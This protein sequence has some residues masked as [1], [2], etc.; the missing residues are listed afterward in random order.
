MKVSSHIHSRSP[1]PVVI[2]VLFIHCTLGF[3]ECKTGLIAY[4]K[5]PIAHAEN[6]TTYPWSSITLSSPNAKYATQYSL[7]SNRYQNT[8]FLLPPLFMTFGIKWSLGKPDPLVVW[9]IFGQIQPIVSH[10]NYN[11]VQFRVFIPA[12]IL[13]CFLLSFFVSLVFL[14][15][16]LFCVLLLSLCWLYK[17]HSCC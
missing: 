15:F 7:R 11:I 9:K 8:G 4:V 17:R 2:Q 10:L 6:R 5:T 14:V 13:Y 12:R 3:V 16:M 1:F